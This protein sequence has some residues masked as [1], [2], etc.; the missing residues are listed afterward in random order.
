MEKQ[1]FY[2]IK[3]KP[4]DPFQDEA[5]IQLGR[6]QLILFDGDFDET[7]LAGLEYS[8]ADITTSKYYKGL[9]SSAVIFD[10]GTE[11]PLSENEKSMKIIYLQR[12]DFEEVFPLIKK[13]AGS[14]K[15][16]YFRFNK[17]FSPDLI[18]FAK[19]P[20][21]NVPT[22]GLDELYNCIYSNKFDYVYKVV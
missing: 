13:I 19:L 9:E 18:Y 6:Y 17:S 7:L 4:K 16:F 12:F 15:K 11:R 14:C 3:E 20:E 22:V 1:L 5:D 21:E 8:K 2:T 10:E